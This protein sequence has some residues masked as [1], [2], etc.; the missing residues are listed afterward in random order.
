MSSEKHTTC[1]S[2]KE[3]ISLSLK[4]VRRRSMKR[5]LTLLSIASGSAFIS[6]LLTVASILQMADG[7]V[8]TYQYWVLIVAVLVWEVAIV[9]SALLSIAERSREIGIMEALG[10]T[11]SAIIKILV[12]ES[13]M[14]GLLGGSLGAAAG[15]LIVVTV[16]GLQLSWSIVLAVPPQTYI[17]NFALTVTVS[18]LLSMIAALYPISRATR[19]VPADA[20]KREI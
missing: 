14:F 15:W 19:L 16:Y 11:S 17:F 8:G 7:K 1:F 12:I 10:A 9:N 6:M 13:A 4:A 3:A 5:T 20:L 18:V 2:I